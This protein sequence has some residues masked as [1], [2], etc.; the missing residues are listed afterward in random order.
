MLAPRLQRFLSRY[1]L[2][3]LEISVS[4]HRE[5]MMTGVDVAVRFGPTEP[6]SLIARKLVETRIY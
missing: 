4:N 1:P 3:S 6:S 5:E 2:L